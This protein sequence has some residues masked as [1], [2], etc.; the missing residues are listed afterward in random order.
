MK[1]IFRLAAILCVATCS[2]VGTALAQEPSP[3][4]TIEVSPTPT[5]TPGSGIT[6]VTTN[7]ASPAEISVVAGCQSFLDSGVE[8]SQMTAACQDIVA[9]TA[10]GTA[11]LE[12][13]GELEFTPDA[14]FGFGQPKDPLCNNVVAAS[15]GATTQCTDACIARNWP[16][17]TCHVIKPGL[18]DLW[19]SYCACGKF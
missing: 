2:W 12:L 5:S 18:F 14:T 3:S 15:C 13:A 6:T 4:P 10:S 16:N 8:N 9:S 19:D 11:T 17:C 1:T 7:L